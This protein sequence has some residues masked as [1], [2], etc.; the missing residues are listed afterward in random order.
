MKDGMIH[1][2]VR[3]REPVETSQVI[4]ISPSAYNAL[5]EIYNEC[6]LSMKDLVS[7]II[8][9]SVGRVVFDKEEGY[10]DAK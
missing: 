7:L 6:T 4:R 5:I 2:P 3:K 9:E 10:C 8:L 1:I